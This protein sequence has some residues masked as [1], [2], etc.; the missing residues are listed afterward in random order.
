[1]SIQELSITNNQ[2]KRL[3]KALPDEN[4]LIQDES[5]ELVIN[6]SAYRVFKDLKKNTPVEDILA[7]E[8]DDSAEYWIFS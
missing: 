3:L 6:V 2:A 1:M 8:L 4:I 5:G 7:E